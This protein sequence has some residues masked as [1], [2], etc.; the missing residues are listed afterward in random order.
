MAIGAAPSPTD[1]RTEAR[2]WLTGGTCSGSSGTGPEAGPEPEASGGLRERRQAAGTRGRAEA[3]RPRTPASPLLSGRRCHGGETRGPQPGS[4]SP[5][6]SQG[7]SHRRWC[8]S[9]VPPNTLE[10]GS[11][12][13]VGVG[14]HPPCPLWHLQL[15]VTTPSPTNKHLLKEQTGPEHGLWEAQPPGQPMPARVLL[16]PKSLITRNSQGVGHQTPPGPPVRLAGTARPAG[17]AQ[18]LGPGRLIEHEAHATNHP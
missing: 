10:Q 6:T 3:D 1:G 18:N 13:S 8:P 15:D 12:V 17:Q 4:G 14:T 7:V 16:S 2:R 5:A 9:P 11:L